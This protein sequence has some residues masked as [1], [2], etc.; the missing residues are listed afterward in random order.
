[1]TLLVFLLPQP[2]LSACKQ[3][4]QV[5]VNAASLR[6]HVEPRIN[7]T[8]RMLSMPRD[9]FIVVDSDPEHSFGGALRSTCL[10]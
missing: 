5:H 1:M 8:V 2:A 10:C 4:L 9:A 7:T 3:E 6:V